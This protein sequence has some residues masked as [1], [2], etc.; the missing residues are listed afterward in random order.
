MHSSTAALCWRSQVNWKHSSSL[1][2]VTL[3]IAL[4]ICR[5]FPRSR[6]TARVFADPPWLFPLFAATCL[7]LAAALPAGEKRKQSKP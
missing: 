5:P 1:L 3:T 7:L 4:I 6:R 2:H